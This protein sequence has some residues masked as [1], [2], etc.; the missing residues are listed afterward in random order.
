VANRPTAKDA[1]L[2]DNARAAAVKLREVGEPV[3]ADAVETLLTPN[4]WA[5]LGRLRSGEGGT[6][7]SPNKSMWL[8]TS[9]KQRAIAGA[10]ADRRDVLSV[11]VEGLE[12]FL[13]GE[14]VPSRPPRAPRGS[15]PSKTSLTARVPDDLWD[16]ATTYG[17]EHAEELGWT[18]VASQV[19]VAYLA[20][21][22]PEPAPVE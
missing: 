1:A 21:L 3:L 10:E 9:L 2:R 16:A 18:P 7:L 19:A 13:R 12:K 6:E 11:V 15:A 22:Y 8:E 14:F 17:A 5:I 4:G 20:Q